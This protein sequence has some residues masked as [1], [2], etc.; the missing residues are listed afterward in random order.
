MEHNNDDIQ[1]NINDTMTEAAIKETLQG[2][3]LKWRDATGDDL[4]LE[5]VG[6]IRLG[7]LLKRLYPHGIRLKISVH[8]MEGRIKSAK[9]GSWG[10]S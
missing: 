1:P 7:A 4:D 9:R 5:R 2:I 8:D 6:K 10:P 3:R